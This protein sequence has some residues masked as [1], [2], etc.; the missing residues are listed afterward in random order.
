MH[1]LR[2][3]RRGVQERQR[4]VIRQRESLASGAVTA[5]PG[6][7]ASERV[8]K[9]VAQMDKEGFG[10]CTNEGECEAKCPKQIPLSNIARMNRDYVVAK[11]KEWFS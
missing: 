1:R 8:T 9:M 7:N 5:R 3:M 6:R 11:A 4:D 2:S 10:N